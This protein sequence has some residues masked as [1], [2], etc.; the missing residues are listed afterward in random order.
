[1]RKLA[2]T[3]D[4]GVR[5][6]G[7]NSAVSPGP[8]AAPLAPRTRPQS[9]VEILDKVGIIH[10]VRLASHQVFD[11]ILDQRRHVAPGIHGGNCCAIDGAARNRALQLNMFG[12]TVVAGARPVGV[13]YLDTHGLHSRLLLDRD[14]VLGRAGTILTLIT[15]VRYHT[16]IT[17]QTRD[18]R[19]L[20]LE[21]VRASRV[22]NQSCAQSP[23]ATFATFNHPR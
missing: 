14:T 21:H 20:D 10:A 4:P 17:T 7:L 8:L 15:V 23:H 16:L 3:S 9:S 2:L 18:G 13:L 6:S 22:L 5:W 11:E 19:L 12:A 1:M